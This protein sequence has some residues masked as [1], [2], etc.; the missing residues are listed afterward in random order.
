MET[1]SA[2][3]IEDRVA[4]SMAAVP[5]AVITGIQARGAIVKVAGKRADAGGQ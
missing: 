2:R 5:R 4:I 3:P 1:L